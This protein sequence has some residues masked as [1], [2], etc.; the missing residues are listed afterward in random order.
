MKTGGTGVELRV[1]QPPVNQRRE[2]VEVR[3]PKGPPG[4][5][6]PR[7]RARKRWEETDPAHPGGKAHLYQARRECPFSL[8]AA[9]VLSVRPHIMLP[10]EAV[11]KV[12][13]RG[14]L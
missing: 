5:E 8:V 10:A 11:L 3:I 12:A 7:K 14:L 2:L 9:L 6:L 13:Y 4:R 1:A